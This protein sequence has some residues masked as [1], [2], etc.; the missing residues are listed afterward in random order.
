MVKFQRNAYIYT[1]RFWSPVA[2]VY[3]KLKS[4]KFQVFSGS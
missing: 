2:P 4:A 3:L 1:R